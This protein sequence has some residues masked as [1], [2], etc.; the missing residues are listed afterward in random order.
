MNS[1]RLIAVPP[2]GLGRD[3][4]AVKTGALEGAIVVRFG[5]KAD[6]AA[7][8]SNVRFASNSGLRNAGLRSAK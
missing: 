2:E 4:V 1:R 5:S 7:R 8:S 3:I 6:I